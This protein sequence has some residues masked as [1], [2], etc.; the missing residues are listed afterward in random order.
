MR[1]IAGRFRRRKLHSSNDVTRPITDR[2]KEA[3]FQYIESDLQGRKVADIFSGTGSLGLECLSRGAAGVTFIEQDVKAFELLRKNV[4][5]L[6]IEDEVLCW[7]ADALLSSFKPKNVPHLVPFDIIMFDPPYKMARQ[8]RP[9]KKLYH[10]LERLAK[11]DVSAP[12]A[13]LFFRTSK[14]EEFE[15]PPVWKLEWTFAISSMKI[16]QYRVSNQ[17]GESPT[18]GIPDSEPSPHQ[19]H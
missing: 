19:I 1:I 14:H 12:D 8:L 4:D 16:L 13:Q 10:S 15:I 2:V 5:Q 3:L 6:G 9:G 11:P 17:A 18:A 7:R